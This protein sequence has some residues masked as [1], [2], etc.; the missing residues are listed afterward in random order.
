MVPGFAV[1]AREADHPCTLVRRASSQWLD[2]VRQDGLSGRHTL[3]A[4]TWVP[5]RRIPVGVLPV[6]GADAAGSSGCHHPFSG[7]VQATGRGGGVCQFAQL[8]RKFTAADRRV[9]IA[10]TREGDPHGPALAFTPEAWHAFVAGIPAGG[11]PTG[12]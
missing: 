8:I 7:W 1:C 3:A 4:G 6:G 5:E 10:R 12:P 2:A 11:F 9:R